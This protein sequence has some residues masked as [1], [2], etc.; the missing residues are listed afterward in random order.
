M[1]MEELRPAGAPGTDNHNAPMVLEIAR[2]LAA[3]GTI[4][5]AAPGMLATV[6]RSL[7]WEYG[8]LWEVDRAGKSLRC[9]GTWHDPSLRFTEFI[10]QSRASTF[11]RGVGLPGRVW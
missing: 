9:V 10:E 7:G 3:S 2:I 4:G 11:T 5:D 1:R 6:C 8:A